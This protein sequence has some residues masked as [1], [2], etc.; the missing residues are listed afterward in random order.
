MAA[1]RAHDLEDHDLL[2]PRPQNRLARLARYL[3]YRFPWL[4]NVLSLAPRLVA[5][6]WWLRKIRK[7]GAGRPLSALP[8]E[9]YR[10][11]NTVFILGTGASIN[12]YPDEWWDT[13]KAH[14]SIGIN[15]FLLHD[16]VPTFHVMEGVHGQRTT[17]LTTR[18]VERGDYRNVPLIVQKQL[19]N[20]S[21]N[22]VKPRINALLGLP[23]QVR[24]NTYLPI[25]FLAPGRTQ[26]DMEA[27]YRAS[28]RLGLWRPK[29]RFLLL[30]K[31]RGSVAFMINLAVR[32]GYTRI[33]LCGIDLNHTEFFYDSRRED[34]EKKG[35]LAPVN[36]ETGPV[37]ST[38]DPTINPVTIHHV[39]VA[40][41]RLIL[42]PAGIELFV[43]SKSS[44]LYPELPYFDWEVAGATTDAQG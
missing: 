24:S 29:R 40:I 28:E 3:N 4:Y 36:D 38:N 2:S 15:F 23:P 30:T 34:L 33:V 1:D 31:R 39:V 42:R 10:S 32:A 11:S 44:A 37:H 41:D 12:D 27:S 7:A 26:E 25:D 20:L 19:T 43:G 18:Y 35:M 17:L 14:D 9:R 16:H 13:I 8:F 6:L 22:R 21:R 5:S